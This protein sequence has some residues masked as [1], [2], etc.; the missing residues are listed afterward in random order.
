MPVFFA[1]RSVVRI[2]ALAVFYQ[3]G[4]EPDEIVADLCGAGGLEGD[5]Q[6]FTLP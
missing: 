4:G 5:A 6:R 2:V 3:N 1:W